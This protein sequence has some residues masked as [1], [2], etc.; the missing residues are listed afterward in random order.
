MC[1]KRHGEFVFAVRGLQK[2]VQSKEKETGAA[3]QV[4]KK[5]KRGFLYLANEYPEKS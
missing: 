3:Q 4:S 1:N 2:R 5:V